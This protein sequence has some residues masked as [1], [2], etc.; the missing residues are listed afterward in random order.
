MGLLLRLF[1][2]KPEYVYGTAGS[3]NGQARRHRSGRVEFVLWKAG[4][5]GHTEDYWHAMHEDWWHTFK[6]G[7]Q[8]VDA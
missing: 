2:R 4:E 7:G 3:N 8:D 1:S 5:R 6:E